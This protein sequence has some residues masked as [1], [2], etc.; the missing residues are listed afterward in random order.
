MQEIRVTLETLDLGGLVAPAVE[1]LD[2]PIS[3][4]LLRHQFVIVALG[5]LHG[6]LVIVAGADVFFYQVTNELTKLEHLL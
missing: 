6:K 1:G 3:L 4:A 2:L 5:V